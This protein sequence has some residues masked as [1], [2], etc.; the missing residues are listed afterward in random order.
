MSTHNMFLWRN[1][2]NSFLDTS[3]LEL[4]EIFFF[5]TWCTLVYIWYCRSPDIY[6]ATQRNDNHKRWT[7]EPGV[8]C[9]GGS[10]SQGHLAAWGHYTGAEW[11]CL[12]Q[13]WQTVKIYIEWYANMLKFF[14]VQKL[15]TFFSTKNIRILY[16]ESAKTVMK[17]P[18][19]SSLS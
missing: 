11:I 2:K 16:I 5:L 14:A 1:K 13:V 19:T 3:Y 17:S 6:W 7:Y 18:L 10:I 8:L 15:L 4:Y 9:A 12:I